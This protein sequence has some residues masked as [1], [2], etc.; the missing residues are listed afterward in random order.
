M[1]APNSSRNTSQAVR[2]MIPVGGGT[3]SDP[4]NAARNPPRAAG[5]PS[6]TSRRSG[7]T[8]TIER[9][10]PYSARKTISGTHG[11]PSC[12][13]PTTSVPASSDAD[14][15]D[16]EQHSVAVVAGG[17]GWGR[18]VAGAQQLRNRQQAR[19]RR[20]GPGTA[21]AGEEGDQ[22]DRG[23]AALQHLPRQFVAGG[24]EPLHASTLGQ[25]PRSPPGRVSSGCRWSR[26]GRRRARRTP[27]C[28]RVAGWHFA[29][30]NPTRSGR[31]VG[32]RSRASS[33]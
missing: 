25:E 6:R 28:S 11:G 26:T 1:P 12:G 33:A 2:M 7:P 31:A 27:R 19:A 29:H 17:T 30:R 24:V 20:A 22:V 9:Y 14:D 15:G 32:R 8:F 10:R 13:S 21:A 23:D 4:R 5:S 18:G 3:A 16:G